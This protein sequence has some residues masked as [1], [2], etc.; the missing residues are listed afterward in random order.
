MYYRGTPKKRLF[1]VSSESEFSDSSEVIHSAGNSP[2][3]EQIVTYSNASETPP[4]SN[5]ALAILSTE[6]VS[7]QVGFS[8]SDA[9]EVTLEITSLPDADRPDP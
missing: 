4:D 8:L 7:Q 3:H 6:A 2:K 1:L 5:L 9:P